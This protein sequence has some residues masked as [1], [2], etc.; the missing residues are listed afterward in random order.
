MERRNWSFKTL[1]RTF[2]V[3]ASEGPAFVSTPS[4]SLSPTTVPTVSPTL[5]PVIT[6]VATIISTPVSTLPPTPE[7]G[8][9]T[10]TIG[11]FIMGIGVLMSSFFVY[12]KQDA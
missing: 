6:P 4:A 8:S 11:L 2:I 1:T 5:V 7:T 9:L 10:P 12:K 3:N